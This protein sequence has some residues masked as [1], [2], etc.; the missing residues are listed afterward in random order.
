[1]TETSPRRS[2]KLA[3]SLAQNR[4]LDGF[5]GSS[6]A[7]ARWW[8][9]AAIYQVYVRSFC[10]GNGDGQ[11]D[12]AGLAGKLDYIKSLGVDAIWLS[13][14]HPSPNRDWGYDE[15]WIGDSQIAS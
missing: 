1:M 6:P 8:R 10:D 13:P 7:A 14:I 15:G 9:G 11:G 5:A 2:P 12:F 4:P 3:A